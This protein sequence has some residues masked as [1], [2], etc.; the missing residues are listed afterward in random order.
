MTPTRTVALLGAGLLGRAVAERLRSVGYDLTV[1]NRTATKAL[2]LQALGIFV[3]G[4][5]EL[6]L[7][8]ANEVLLFLSDAPA[9]Q[10]VLFAPACAAA[11]RGKTVVQMGTIG[12]EESVELHERVAHCGGWYCEAPVLGSVAEAKAGTLLIMAG[13]TPEQFSRLAPLFSSLSRDPRLIGPV[14]KAAAL[15]LALNQL[16]AAEISA[17][18]VSLGLVLRSGIATDSFMAV[19]RESALFAPTFEKKLPRLLKRDYRHPNF[20]TRHLLKDL[21]LA[22]KEAGRLGLETST[23]NGLRGVLQRALVQGLGE[24]D[25]SALYD[26]VNPVKE[27]RDR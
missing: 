18:A 1:Y 15:K 8:Q 26:V 24:V 21:E 22:A 11:L 13:A 16:I 5:P 9:I 27:S 6:A 17:F 23:L 4:T 20:S 14:G 10:A 2:S 12:V 25:Y 19:L 7:S 3:V